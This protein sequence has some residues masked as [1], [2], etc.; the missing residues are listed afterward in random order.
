[1]GYTGLHSEIELDQT[2]TI[3]GKSIAEITAIARPGQYSSAGFIS[4]D[5]DII[6]ALKG[7]NRLVK[8]MGLMHRQI[9]TPMRM[10]KLKCGRNLLS[11]K[12]IEKSVSLNEAKF[13]Y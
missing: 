2:K 1:M 9:V 13:Q 12:L 7:D 11:K 4:Q 3:T 10:K 5:E 6:S 8:Q